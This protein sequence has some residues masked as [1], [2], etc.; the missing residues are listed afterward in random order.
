LARAAGRGLFAEAADEFLRHQLPTGAWGQRAD[1]ERGNAIATTQVLRVLARAGVPAWDEAVV[2]AITYLATD[3]LDHVSPVEQ[4]GRGTYTRYIS[5]ALE[6][7]AVFREPL[8]A[9]ALGEARRNQLRWLLGMRRGG[10]WGEAPG[11]EPSAFATARVV[12]ALRAN[13]ATAAQ[14]E[15]A[16]RFLLDV[17]AALGYWQAAGAAPSPGVTAECVMA[18]H[19]LD[20]EVDERLKYACSWLRTNQRLWLRQTETETLPG[21]TWVHACYASVLDALSCLEDVDPVLVRA[22]HDFVSELRHGRGWRFPG[23]AH[24]SAR[25]AE[26]VV[27]LFDVLVRGMLV[28]ETS[29]LIQLYGPDADVV[30]AE[31]GWTIE[32]NGRPDAR[33]QVSDYAKRIDLRPRLWDLLDALAAEHRRQDGRFIGRAEVMREMGLRSSGSLSKEMTRLSEALAAATGGRLR[34]VVAQAGR[35]RWRL[36]GRIETPGE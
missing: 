31:P 30:E 14:I 17:Q 24:A 20:R 27:S 10:A 26:A 7:L 15:P 32:L 21:V 4:G 33:V 34:T 5:F 2:R 8:A 13:R 12:R 22:V 9:P 19:G 23:E 36:T 6:G 29:T 16:V 25:G 3:P 18:L 28:A 11:L 1:A 35:G